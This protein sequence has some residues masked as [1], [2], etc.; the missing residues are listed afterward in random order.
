M[1]DKYA[2]IFTRIKAAFIDSIVMVVLMYAAT[3]ILNLFETIPNYVRISVFIFICLVY[4]P[5]LV[6]SFGATVGHFF[7]DIV[8]KRENNEQRNILLPKA[9]IRF[10]FKFCLGWISLLTISGHEKRKAIHDHVGGSVV[11]K[12]RTTQKDG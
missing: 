7:S 9:I 2:Q 1:E 8:V 3:E 6:S 5:I 12:Y 10:I 11:L 4:E